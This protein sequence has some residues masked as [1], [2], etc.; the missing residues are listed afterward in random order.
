MM[1][2][3]GVEGDPWEYMKHSG[4]DDMRASTFFIGYHAGLKTMSAGVHSYSLDD[5]G[6]YQHE[7]FA[8][9]PTSFN[10]ASS[11]ALDNLE[12]A[13]GRELNGSDHDL[14]LSLGFQ[15]LHGLKNGR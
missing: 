2:K 8:L 9:M 10:G 11:G 3:E 14:K 6:E 12:K 7:K 5:A 15:F 4:H 1:S 13:L